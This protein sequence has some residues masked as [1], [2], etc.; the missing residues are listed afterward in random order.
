M[1]ELGGLGGSRASESFKD[2]GQSQ[3]EGSRAET[4]K[5]LH[6]D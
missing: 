1:V 5:K 2:G 3:P 4:L 6:K